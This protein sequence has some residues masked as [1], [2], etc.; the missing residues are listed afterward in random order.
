MIVPMK[1][2][3]IISV[4]H[5]KVGTI[6]ELAK[7]GV[8]HVAATDLFESEDRATI[9]MAIETNARALSIL[10]SIKSK[11]TLAPE[12]DIKTLSPEKKAEKIL[13]IA[14]EN[15]NFA[16]DISVLSGKIESLTPWGDF[17]PEDLRR[18][19]GKGVFVYFCEKNKSD[20][21]IVPDGVQI[22]IVSETRSKTLFVMF[23]SSKL[24]ES[25]IPLAEL[26]RSKSLSQ[27]VAEK[28]VLEENIKENFAKIAGMKI[29]SDEIR[30]AQMEFTQR[31]EIAEALDAMKGKG[32]LSCI[33]GY[34]PK[35]DEVSLKK[36]ALQHGWGLVLEDAVLDDRFVPTFIEIPKIFRII[37]PVF[38]F[39]GV[40]PGYDEVDVSVCF[41][42]FFSI[43][44]AMIVGD[45]GYGSL[46]LVAAIF[47]KIK[48]SA[49][50]EFKLPLNLLV[51][52]SVSTIVWGSLSGTWFNIASDKLPAPMR[53]IN[54]LTDSATKDGLIQ[55]ICFI[56]AGFHLSLAR[57]WKAI[58]L[59][60]LKS[61]GQ[62][63]WAAMIWANFFVVKGLLVDGGVF[64]NFISYL[65]GVSIVLLLFFYVNW[66]SL[67]DVF[68][69]PFSIISSFTDVL[70]YIRLY[71]VGLAGCSL[72]LITN[73]IGAMFFGGHPLLII[74]GVMII[75][76][77]HSLNITLC[78]LGVLVHGVRLNA[79]EFSNHM[80]LQ[81]KGFKY[82][83]L[84]LVA[85]NDNIK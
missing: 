21:V 12:I 16:K 75:L 30:D 1:K 37:R 55:T 67:G 20:E 52:L 3:T 73:E 6:S 27:L 5:E 11:A 35:R 44:F 69:F 10:S 9:N 79:L 17:N 43:F 4:A 82:C 18:L 50:R 70:S 22:H 59:S 15:A 85:N 19:N 84:K 53:G 33:S 41:L 49:N 8:L 32:N 7:L 54:A 76:F 56:L 80:E 72:A 42:F 68:N 63:G 29:F 40:E 48:F 25:N 66:K 31:R 81:W 61:L 74:F 38:E 45:A 62:L 64:P 23:S 34:V 26:D 71:A 39:I 77:G 58:L 60:S 65:Y 78:F 36:S 28:A 2:I 83:P 57:I 46:F 51:V 47:A 13:A 14:E 24:D